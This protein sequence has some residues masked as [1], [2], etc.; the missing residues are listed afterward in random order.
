[1]IKS[2][3]LEGETRKEGSGLGRWLGNYKTE[4]LG[5]AFLPNRKWSITQSEGGVAT[6]GLSPVP[7]T[8]FAGGT[9]PMLSIGP[10]ERLEARFRKGGGKEASK[11]DSPFDLC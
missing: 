6:Q 3:Y 11:G 9:F 7:G 10:A 4:L 2:C 8:H 1:M 5:N